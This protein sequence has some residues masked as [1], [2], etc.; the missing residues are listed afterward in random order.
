MAP[1]APVQTALLCARCKREFPQ[2]GLM[3]IAGNWI[4]GGCKPAYLSQV[5]AAELHHHHRS[6]VL[7][8]A[9]DSAP[10]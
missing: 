4:C 9:F 6:R 7:A 10:A 3:Q 2:S 1:E 8:L 5:L